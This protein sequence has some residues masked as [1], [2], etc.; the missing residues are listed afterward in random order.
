MTP[1]EPV[2][3]F[4]CIDQTEDIWD[5]VRMK[6]IEPAGHDYHRSVVPLHVVEYCGSLI[7]VEETLIHEL[8]RMSDDEADAAGEAGAEDMANLMQKLQSAASYLLPPIEIWTLEDYETSE[9]SIVIGQHML[10]ID[11]CI[12]EEKRN[13]DQFHEVRGWNIVACGPL[14]EE[15][16]LV[17]TTIDEIALSI[18]DIAYMTLRSKFSQGESD[19]LAH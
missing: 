17:H 12:T 2:I 16:I 18:I 14:V 10:T 1:N 11:P 6:Y 9:E 3:V 7:T 15:H 13:N 5:F 8:I 19:G 4:H